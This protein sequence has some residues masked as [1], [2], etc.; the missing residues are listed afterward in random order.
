MQVSVTFI[1][2]EK[3][4][5]QKLVRQ[6]RQFCCLA[7]AQLILVSSK[8]LPDPWTYPFLARDKDLTATSLACDWLNAEA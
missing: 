5:R 1:L 4:A 8:G 6:S 3:G 7:P 2:K